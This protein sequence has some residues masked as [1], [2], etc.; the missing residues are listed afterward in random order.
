MILFLSTFQLWEFL[1]Q[2][3]EYSDRTVD[4]FC[5]QQNILKLTLLSL[6]LDGFYM[7][8]CQLEKTALVATAVTRLNQWWAENVSNKST[9]LPNSSLYIHISPAAFHFHYSRSP[10]HWD[11]EETH[12]QFKESQSKQHFRLFDDVWLRWNENRY[13]CV[14]LFVCDT[15]VTWFTWVTTCWPTLRTD[16]NALCLWHLDSNTDQSEKS[17]SCCSSFKLLFYLFFIF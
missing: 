10:T 4:Q 15:W 11:T 7:S 9:W 12:I 16:Y 2:L 13:E 17:N 3:W 8:G 5:V 14:C 6:T 1:K